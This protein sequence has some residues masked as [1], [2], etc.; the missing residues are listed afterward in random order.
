MCTGPLLLQGPAACGLLHCS[1]VRMSW[2]PSPECGFL[3]LLPGIPSEYEAP[4][5]ATLGLASRVVRL[6]EQPHLGP[7][8]P[9]QPSQPRASLQAEEGL[10]ADSTGSFPAMLPSLG[11]RSLPGGPWGHLRTTLGAVQVTVQMET[12]FWAFVSLNILYTES[13]F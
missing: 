12:D 7:R 8:G 13:Y 1:A 2:V 6:S 5:H 9:Q 11:P 3:F 4:V 10:R